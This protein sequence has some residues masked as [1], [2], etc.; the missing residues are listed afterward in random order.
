MTVKITEEMLSEL[1]NRVTADMSPKRAR[2]TLEV[3]KMAERLCAMFCPEQTDKMRAAALLHDLTKEY[4]LE[5]HLEICKR[6][7]LPVSERDIC[8]PKTFHARTAAAIIPEAYG[9]FGDEEIILAVRYHTTGREGMTL[10]EKIIYLAD[11]IDMSRTFLD[12]VR[13]REYFFSA[14]PEKM[15]EK[16][17]LVHLDKTIVMSYDMTV[18][19]LIAEGAPISEETFKSRNELILKLKK[20]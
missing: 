11:Y 9:E 8:S 4:T 10:T 16:D 13:L 17:R 20:A 18:S 1:R 5:G 2:H 3:E 14:E 15:S 6:H 19:G 12:C 7:G